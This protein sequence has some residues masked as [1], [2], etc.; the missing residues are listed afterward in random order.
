AQ[1]PHRTARLLPAP[2][3]LA[4]VATVGGTAGGVAPYHVGGDTAICRV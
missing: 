3:R 2:A 4:P 1:R